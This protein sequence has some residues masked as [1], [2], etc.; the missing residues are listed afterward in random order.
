MSMMDAHPE[1]ASD[2]SQGRSAVH[3]KQ[4]R[5]SPDEPPLHR[6]DGPTFERMAA[7]GLIKGKTELVEDVILRIP[8]DS[9]A[10]R[11]CIQD[12]Y[13]ALRPG[14]AKPKFISVQSTHRFSSS[15][16]PEPDLALLDRA[17]IDGAITDE[18]PSLMIEVARESLRYDLGRKALLYAHHGVAEYWVVDLVGRKIHVFRGPLEGETVAEAWAEHRIASGNDEV[19]P[20]CAEAVTVVVKEVIP[21]VSA[22]TD[23][24]PEQDEDSLEAS[25]NA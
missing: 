24:S 18:T 6:V 21:A 3:L 23:K 25:G 1:A 12:L 9:N 17:P 11:V 2:P 5:L 22:R 8:P 13:D 14:W 15:S 16:Q 10:H 20:L 7:S 4:I 19:S